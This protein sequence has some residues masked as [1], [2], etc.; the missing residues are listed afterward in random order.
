MQIN[1][2]NYLINATIVDNL[3]YAAVNKMKGQNLA[4]N[5]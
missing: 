4:N 3:F 5:T 1:F 2:P